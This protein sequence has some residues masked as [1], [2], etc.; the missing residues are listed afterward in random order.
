MT[1]QDVIQLMRNIEVTI[2]CPT[3]LIARLTDETAQHK[4]EFLRKNQCTYSVPSQESRA[5][6]EAGLM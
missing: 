3:N 4:R 1:S 6:M 5:N 2:Q